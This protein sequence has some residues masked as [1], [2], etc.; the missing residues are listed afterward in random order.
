MGPLSRVARAS[1]ILAAGLVALT[2]AACSEYE[3]S[4]P[5]HM[6]PLDSK[7]RNL[8][9]RKG[10]DLRSPILIR[11][12]KE[13]ATLEVW[14]QERRTGRYTFLKDYEI[15]AWSGVLGPKIREGD[16]QA[17][18]G[19]YTIRPAQMN[20]DSSYYLAFNMGYP[21]EFDRSLGRTGA[22]LM[23][24]GAC[25]SRGCY[26]MTDE[27]IQEIYTL[28]RLAFQGGQRDF[29]VQAFPFRMTAENMA[30]HRDDPNMPFWMM[31]KEGYD[32]FNLLGQPPKVD[33][34]DHRYIF[35]STPAEGRTFNASAECPAMSMPESVR[36]AVG[37]KEARDNQRM[38]ELA[39]R[40]G[41]N[42]LQAMQL[43]LATPSSV[44]RSISAPMSVATAPVSLEP[45]E[46]STTA[47]V[48][49]ATAVT[50][51]EPTAFAPTELVPAAAA[52]EAPPAAVPVPTAKPAAPVAVARVPDPAPPA[53][54]P[55]ADV[56]SAFLPVPELR[57]G[58][59]DTPTAPAGE[60][61]SPSTG[62]EATLEERMLAGSTP[63]DSGV[64][65][66]YATASE[67]EDGLTGMVLKLIKKQ[68]QDGAA[69][70]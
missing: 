55:V 49:A 54:E 28:G 6:R 33:V 63:D 69:P 39:S 70:N 34:C 7:T 14:K 15:C 24:H 37:E 13:E 45:T 32:H 25:S 12:F 2:L 19:F 38:L 58:E 10:M 65:N 8:V 35:N 27:S 31:L 42:G 9:D 59:I 30:R 1:L 21:N 11:I 43:A 46:P 56:D 3:G 48:S 22:E 47:S 40:E 5:K 44:A 67:E 62:S 68:Q 4:L 64:A 51:A 20:P 18:E 17:P 41:G 60:L 29:Q 16:R 52:V 36:V 26:S 61:G 50:A 66:S 53:S 57:T 23:V